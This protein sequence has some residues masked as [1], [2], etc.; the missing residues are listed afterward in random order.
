MTVTGTTG[1]GPSAAE[2]AFGE[3]LRRLGR[4]YRPVPLLELLLGV[5]ERAAQEMAG[6]ALATSD[7]AEHLLADMPMTLRN[8]EV[9]SDQAPQRC[10]G[11]LRG[12]V[13]WSE[14]LSARSASAGDPALYV[15][16]SVTRAYDTAANR[17]LVAALHAVRSA[18]YAVRAHRAVGSA[19]VRAARHNASC[20]DRFLDHRSLIDVPRTSPDQR[21]LRRAG[22]GRRRRTYRPAMALL[23]RAGDLLGPRPLAAAAD[24]QSV[25]A[26][27]LLARCLTAAET[28]AH[29]R[30]VEV[31]AL[32]PHLG[33][34]AAGPIGYRRADRA[35][36]EVTIGGITVR[37]DSTDEVLSASLMLVQQRAS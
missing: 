3:I 29:R 27:E 22:A 10:L 16:S 4:P 37:R 31:P 28:I 32:R 7:E 9:S 15:C 24:E 6:V 33:S 36:P 19:A 2:A 34:L 30:D 35:T 5:S 14:T 17:V 20:A 21:V 26:A 13:M 23:A 25:Y 11:E 12:P 8:L 18:G 1:D